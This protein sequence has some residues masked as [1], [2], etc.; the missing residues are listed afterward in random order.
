MW[1][2]QNLQYSRLTTEGRSVLFTGLFDFS[3]HYPTLPG[4][5]RL[6]PAR[7]GS[8]RQYS[9]LSVIIR[10]FGFF[11]QGSASPRYNSVLPDNIRLC[12]A[13]FG[14]FRQ[15]STLPDIIRHFPIRFGSSQLDSAFL[16]RF[17]ETVRTWKYYI[18]V[19]RPSL[20]HN[21]KQTLLK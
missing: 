7:F 20:K 21:W 2:Q 19:V 15:H 10:L 5:I 18:V 3:R 13:L 1:F 12:P 16:V 17:K 8:S 9:T 14:F 6:F 11:R 4:K